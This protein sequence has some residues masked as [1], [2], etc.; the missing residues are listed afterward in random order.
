MRSNIN[1]AMFRLMELRQFGPT[2]IDVAVIGQGTWK[3]D[4]DSDIVNALL[5]G[6]ELGMTHL[7]TAELYTGA[8]EILRPLVTAHRDDIF[9]VSKVLPDNAAYADTIAAC[10]RSLQ[11]LGV[12]YLDAY[13][14]HWNGGRV[15]LAETM[16]AMLDLIAAGKIRF[17]GVSN[18]D[19]PELEEA[20]AAL[21]DTPLCCNQVIYNPGDRAIE[22]DVLP[23]CEAHGVAERNHARTGAGV[24]L[25]RPRL[26]CTCT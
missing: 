20:Q 21:G 5:R 25:P 6:I 2:G 23:W 17:P 15:P 3:V 22:D 8:E 18:F 4:G 19:V 24:T 16:G 26:A 9:L 10:D 13:L 1:F 12:E 14:L 7:D 11:T